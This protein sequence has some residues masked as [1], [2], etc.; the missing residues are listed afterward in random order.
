[1]KYELGI[2][3]RIAKTFIDSKLT[4]LAIVAALVLGIIAVMQI[5]REEEPQIIVPMLDV[6]TAMPGA[7]PAEVEQRVTIPLEMVLREIPGVEYVY[8]TSSPG[9]SLIIVRFYVGTRQEDALV[10]VYSKLYANLDHIP[11][12]VSPSIVKSRSIDDVPIL[13][14]TLWG[15]NYD[16][17]HLRQIAAELEHSIKQIDDVSE[18]RILGGQPRSLRVDLSTPKLAS[19]SLSPSAWWQSCNR[20]MQRLRPESSRMRTSRSASKPDRYSP[21]KEDVEQVVLGVSHGRPILLRDVADQIV[22]GPAEPTNYVNFGIGQGAL[23]ADPHAQVGAEFPGRHHYRCQAQGHQCHH[24]R[25]CGSGA[26]RGVQ[27]KRASPRSQ[28]HHDAQLRRNRQGQVGRVTQAPVARHALRHPPDRNLSR[29]AGVG[30]GAARDSG[31]P[32]AY[33][34]HLLSARLHPQ[35]GHAL[36]A[37]LQHRHSGRR[38]NRR[39]RKHRAPL[40]HSGEQ[41]PPAERSGD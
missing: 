24:H 27:R 12:G 32:G 36:R 40:P 25:Q 26:H 29:L 6:M 15:K 3:G 19:Y 11:P 41:G 14:L 28:H 13:A 4:P 35:P 34:R 22:D 18:T 5:P 20:R 39:G 37:D 7:S 8:S 17:Y 10:K 2:A 30:R 31:N 23:R 16:S 9:S 1:M 33:P 38:C 21:R